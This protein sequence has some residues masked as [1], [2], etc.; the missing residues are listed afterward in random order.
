MAVV[1]IKQ[2]NIRSILIG[3]VSPSADVVLYNRHMLEI[4]KVIHAESSK[5]TIMWE[6]II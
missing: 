2:S 3:S 4:I 6:V 1:E 5:L